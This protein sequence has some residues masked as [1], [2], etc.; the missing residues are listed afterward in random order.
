MFINKLEL[1]Y[2]MIIRTYRELSFYVEMFK[3]NNIDLL[4]LEGVGGLS[5]SRIVED[6]MKEREYLK[7]VSHVTPL[8]LYLLGFEHLNQP[9]IFDDCDCLLQNDSNVALLKMFC[10]TSETK[11]INWFTTASRL[12]DEGVPSHYE[13]RSKVII[14]CNDFNNITQKV[15]SLKDR[16]WHLEFKPSNEEILAKMRELLPVVHNELSIEEKKEVYGVIE[17]YVNVAEI[18]LRTFI[19]GLSLYKECKNREMD[20]RVILLSS[21]ELNPKLVLLDKIL[22]DYEKEADRIKVWEE[23]GYSRRNYYEFKLKL[24]AKVP[25]SQENLHEDLSSGIVSSLAQPI[26]TTQNEI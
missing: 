7:I 11:E 25:K 19:K 18:S 5:K 15:S 8:K 9:I 23:A 3:H 14:I 16:G 12:D 6:S 2:I 20:W 22:R 4:I 13:T 1:H 21:I 17:K 26:L 24:S 10:D